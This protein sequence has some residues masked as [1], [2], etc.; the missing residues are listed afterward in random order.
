MVYALN[1]SR[2]SPLFNNT[3]LNKLCHEMNDTYVSIIEDA[4]L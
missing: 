1:P 3:E 4:T 2:L